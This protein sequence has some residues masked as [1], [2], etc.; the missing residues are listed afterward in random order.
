MLT[1]DEILARAKSS[2]DRLPPSA[3]ALSAFTLGCASTATGAFVYRRYWRRIANADW[4]TPDIQ[5]RWLKGHVCS[6]GDSDNFRFYH[7]PGFGWNL[8][9]KFR[10]VPSTAKALKDKTIHIRI[11]GVDAPESAHFGR[12]GQ[13]YAEEALAFLRDAVLGK[14]VYCQMLRRDQYGRVVAVV[15]LP[16][17]LLPGSLVY[18]KCLSLEMLK[19]GWVTVYEQVNAEYGKWGKDEFLRVE[20]EAKARRRGMWQKGTRIETPAEFKRR[21]ANESTAKG[22]VPEDPFENSGWFRRFFRI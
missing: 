3:L 12:P 4:I 18:G 10:T 6:V 15:T 7:Q 16:P 11:A 22:Q 5:G 13:P 1:K 19:A 8:P 21:H 2:L 14:T 17:R 9:L 20:N